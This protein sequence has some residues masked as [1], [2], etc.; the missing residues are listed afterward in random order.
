MTEGA[1]VGLKRVV[2]ETWNSAYFSLY[3]YEPMTS[4]SLKV[5]VGNIHPPTPRYIYSAFDSSDQPID[6]SRMTQGVG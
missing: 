6:G 3:L 5:E 4:Q 2:F 1:E